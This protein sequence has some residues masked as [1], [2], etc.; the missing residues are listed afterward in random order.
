VTRELA[1]GWL[2]PTL[3]PPRYLCLPSQDP[4]SPSASLRG[5]QGRLRP[6]H[7]KR[8]G[9]S[10]VP[11]RENRYWEQRSGYPDTRS[12]V[13]M[14]RSRGDMSTPQKRPPTRHYLQTTSDK[15]RYGRFCR[16]RGRL[17]MRCRWGRSVRCGPGHWSVAGLSGPAE[18]SGGCGQNSRSV[19]RG[20]HRYRVLFQV[21]HARMDMGTSEGSV[22]RR[23]LVPSRA[24]WL[25]RGRKPA[26]PRCS[27][28][29]ERSPW[30]GGAG[31]RFDAGKTRPRGRG[32]GA[33][34][35]S[36]RSLGGLFTLRA[37]ASAI[38]LVARLAVARLRV[39]AVGRRGPTR[40]R[41]LRRGCV[42]GWRRP[43][44]CR[45]RISGSVERRLLRA[46]ASGRRSG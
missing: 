10:A 33:A 5:A 17:C 36:S 43:S 12:A 46:N 24:H 11:A 34:T 15:G 31:Q 19:L 14:G 18:N 3:S 9:S 40:N 23:S 8:R 38:A 39:N 1:G 25:R 44:A 27:A 41:V 6:E 22:H 30:P 35:A 28:R 29:Y 37:V 26:S 16:R 21:L 13:S 2:V 42:A 4:R 45:R 20:G 32:P 7:R